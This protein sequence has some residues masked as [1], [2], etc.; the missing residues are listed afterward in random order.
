MILDDIS[1][2]IPKSNF[3]FDLNFNN[4]LNITI[5]IIIIVIVA[6]FLILC[7][8]SLAVCCTRGNEYSNKYGANPKYVN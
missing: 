3:K 6:A 2:V 5:S 4:A 1:D 8:F 7:I